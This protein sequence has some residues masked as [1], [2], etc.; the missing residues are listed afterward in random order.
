MIDT[1]DKLPD[2]ITLK[3]VMLWITCDIKSNDKLIRVSA[4]SE[5]N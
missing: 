1:N 5:T 4:N 2:D 3:N